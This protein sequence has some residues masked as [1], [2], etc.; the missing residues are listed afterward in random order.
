M[1]FLNRFLP[2]RLTSRI[3]LSMVL[4]V[5]LAGLTTTF[6]INQILARS[7]RQELSNSGRAITLSLGDSLANALLDGNLV[8]IQEAL[9]DTLASNPDVV[10]VFAFGPHTPIVHTFEDG[11]PRGLM[12]ALTAP[13]P[14]P[15]GELL[16][17]TEN[18]LV[19]DFVYRPLD[20]INAEVHIGIS[21]NRIQAEQRRVTGIVLALTAVG[22]LLAAAMTYVFSRLA[23][24]PLVELTQRVHQLGEGRLD[25][26]IS[27][28]TGD[29]VGE[30][31][32][33]FNAMAEKIQA[34][35]RRLSISEVGYRTL[36]SAASEV[37]EGI[38]L[39]SE[40]SGNDGI[41]LFV[42][43]TFARLT[44][45]TPQELIGVNVASVLAP[46]SL[47]LA[48]QSWQ[49]LH[50]GAAQSGVTE[51][52]LAGRHGERYAVETASTRIIYQET[53]AIVWFV[54]DITERKQREQELR[55]RN[56][57]LS[58][59]NAV[60][61][62]MSEPYSPDML[63][64]GLRE[65]L[66][67]LELE[68]GWVTL[69]NADGSGKVVACEGMEFPSLTRFPNCRCGQSL[70]NGQGT[71]VA[72]KE[73]CL[74]SR[75]AESSAEG[76]QHATVPLGRPEKM[77]GA[78]SVAFSSTRS[79]DESNLRLL[80]AIGRQMGIALENARLWEELRQR[81]QLRSELLARSLLAQ[82]GERKRIA[83]ELHDATGQSLNAILFGLKAAESAA[84]NDAAQMPNLLAR[85]KSAVSDTVRELQEIIYALRPSVL[86][87]LG[88]LPALRWYAESR[89]ENEGVQV[90]WK[91]SDGERR[92]PAEIETALFR[93][94]Q[95]A[96]T[97]ISKYAAARRVDFWLTFATARV[98]LQITDDGRGFD[99]N[100]ALAH[101][102]QD[103]RGLG[104][105]GMRERAEL[106][107]GR[108]QVESRPG[109]GTRVTVELPLSEGEI[110]P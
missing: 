58:A 64:R 66:Q 98:A 21:E 49:S 48:Y 18:G 101:H 88:L 3:T 42:N 68:I 13:R 27:L 87:D 37:G 2:H 8:S 20:G 32:A 47:E 103:G 22:C 90:V 94:A 45:F 96:I 26:R 31:A 104:L 62:A 95:E 5:V 63:Q 86:D 15:S 110:T 44:G 46:D 100:E 50:L 40:Q 54:R 4:I 6:A 12:Y 23:T 102:L 28:P 81:E 10:Y 55:L 34:A 106:L 14:G 75:L 79:F 85:L 38:A 1:R 73:E 82:E 107:G 109:A 59:L 70:Q 69:L 19:R 57:E 83:R 51:L 78:L 65:A 35:I 61:F 43:E 99:V 60:A 97:N 25:E 72:V 7:L 33:A 77:L 89:L 108:L 17:L 53:P 36:L 41:L 11:F 71:V 52:T 84:Q 80:S 16:L 29:E 91:I 67:A 9:N 92:L 76:W 105:L 39:I 74:L 24:S 30:L 93:I 56:R